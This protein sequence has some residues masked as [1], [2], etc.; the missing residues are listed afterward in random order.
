MM[1]QRKFHLPAS[2]RGGQCVAA[3]AL[4]FILGLNPIFAAP[5][6]RKPAKTL[7][8]P[9]QT[10]DVPDGLLLGAPE[11]AYPDAQT[12]TDVSGSVTAIY[13]AGGSYTFREEN[14]NN[15]KPLTTHV[16]LDM[17]LIVRYTRSGK[18]EI[19]TTTANG[20]KIISAHAPWAGTRPWHTGTSYWPE[21]RKLRKETY[22]GTATRKYQGSAIPSLTWS[23]L[24]H[25]A[26]FRANLGDAPSNWPSH[27]IQ[28]PCKVQVQETTS[29]DNEREQNTDTTECVLFTHVPSYGTAPTHWAKL[30]NNG[31]KLDPAGAMAGWIE[32]AS[33]RGTTN[34]SF[35]RPMYFDG[36]SWMSPEAARKTHENLDQQPEDENGILWKG[37]VQVYWALGSRMPQGKMSLTPADKDAY[38][39]WI[40][41]AN[42][43][44][45]PEPE[46]LS[47]TASILPKEEGKPAP[48]GRI[49]FWLCDVSHEKGLCT[50]F[51]LDGNTEDDLR[52]VPEQ[53]ITVDPN[54]PR[55][56]YTNAV[57]TQATVSVESRD[58]G[59]YGQLQATCDD[60]GLIA[61][62]ERTGRQVISIP[63]DDNHNNIADAWE[64]QLSLRDPFATEDEDA[65]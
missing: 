15:D 48:K 65:Q 58:M 29:H 60:L 17:T 51:P 10:V 38:Q 36:I 23:K 27:M 50:N 31:S 24:L 63:L 35:T 56:A 25:L 34:G 28:L 11:M 14:Y 64:H 21:Y 43:G 59:A 30:V 9:P 62:D 42:L 13:H 40:P 3:G 52:F 22:S 1:I 20:S 44:N 5:A 8:P 7:M 12:M 61:E 39:R 37:N 47:F 54:N 32:T 55:H 57:C 33:P 6:K 46:P 18:T 41:T 19:V 49:H 2:M 45:G 26:C 4:L 16:Q 53:G